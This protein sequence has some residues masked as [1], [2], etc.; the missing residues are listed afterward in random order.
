M[1]L[2]YRAAKPPVPQRQ[3]DFETIPGKAT[4]TPLWRMAIITLRKR[5]LKGIF[6]IGLVIFDVGHEVL[7]K[8]IKLFHSNCSIWLLSF[9]WDPRRLF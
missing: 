1:V 4:L 5:L 2:A 7:T 9:S 3:H 8:R 6:T